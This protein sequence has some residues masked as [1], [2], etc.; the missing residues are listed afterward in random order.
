MPTNENAAALAGAH[1]VSSQTNLVRANFSGAE[2]L[3]QLS[4]DAGA[5]AR[6]IERGVR[7]AT[8]SA[9]R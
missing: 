8:T 9:M 3:A 2:V 7:H 6:A 5:T 4:I 1:G